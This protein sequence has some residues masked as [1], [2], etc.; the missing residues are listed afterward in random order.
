MSVSNVFIA[1]MADADCRLAFCSAHKLGKVARA[2]QL[3][4]P[5][6]LGGHYSARASVRIIAR[7]TAVAVQA[8]PRGLGTP[9][10][11]NCLAMS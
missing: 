2:I 8:P 7:L 11:V 5:C 9:Q 6:G 3:P 1:K 10:P 4:P